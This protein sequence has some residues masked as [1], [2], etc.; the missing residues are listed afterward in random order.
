M[1]DVLSDFSEAMVSHDHHSGIGAGG[2]LAGEVRLFEEAAFDQLLDS[3]PDRVAGEGQAFLQLVAGIARAKTIVADELGGEEVEDAATLAACA[4]V[5]GNRC[6]AGGLGAFG[7]WTYL[8][9]DLLEARLL[10]EVG[11]AEYHKFLAE[12]DAEL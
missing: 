11:G 1:A 7:E 2:C 5:V 12:L 4:G 6:L 9:I 8:T 3:G 10:L